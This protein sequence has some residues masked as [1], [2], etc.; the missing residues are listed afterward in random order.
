MN[1]RGQFGGSDSEYHRVALAATAAQSN[2]TE[3]A[4]APAQLV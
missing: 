4:A 3:A 2:R 1:K